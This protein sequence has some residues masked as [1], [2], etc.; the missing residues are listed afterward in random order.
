VALARVGT[1]SEDPA[2]LL[3]LGS[4]GFGLSVA[5][6][7]DFFALSAFSNSVNARGLV[8]PFFFFSTNH[9]CVFGATGSSGVP[10]PK[11]ASCLLP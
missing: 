6:V 8:L 11:V 9:R 1:V 7:I 5:R 2:A 3:V 4:F 10:I